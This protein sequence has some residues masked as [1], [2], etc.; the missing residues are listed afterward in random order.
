M[1]FLPILHCH[2]INR[3]HKRSSAPAVHALLVRRLADGMG[4]GRNRRCIS[5]IHGHD[6]AL[7]PAHHSRA[8]HQGCAASDLRRAVQQ[9]QDASLGGESGTGGFVERE[10]S[11]ED[12]RA[13]V[14]FH[15]LEVSVS[16]CM[17]SILLY[18]CKA[19]N[20]LFPF[21]DS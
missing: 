2:I 15:V 7:D 11:F 3:L 5:A 13:A 21:E 6:L 8:G 9:V 14:Y 17:A 16:G 1:Q 20:I 19:A 4:Q 12:V 18:K 10:H